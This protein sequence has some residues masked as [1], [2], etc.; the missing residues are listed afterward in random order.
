MAEVGLK[1]ISSLGVW[2]AMK[3]SIDIISTGFCYLSLLAMDFLQDI[4]F[5]W[6]AIYPLMSDTKLMNEVHE[7][8]LREPSIFQD[9]FILNL[10]AHHLYKSEGNTKSRSKLH[11]VLGYQLSRQAPIHPHCQNRSLALKGH[12]TY[13]EPPGGHPVIPEGRTSNSWWISRTIET[14]N[15]K[16]K[17][18]L[19]TSVRLTKQRAH[20]KHNNMTQPFHTFNLLSWQQ[21]TIRK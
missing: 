8:R 16:Q 9:P 21:S 18:T 5:V 14:E 3:N 1:I 15:R 17:T 11:F 19:P 6:S 4:H 7:K 2:R 12:E 10:H 20:R 13:K